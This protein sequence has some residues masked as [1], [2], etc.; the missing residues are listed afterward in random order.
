MDIY[1]LNS[2]L[3]QL[4]IIDSFKSL[5]W[6]KRYYTCGDF[7]LCMAADLEK[8]KFLQPDN[9]L[10]RE[11]DE[12]VMVIEKIEAHYD[13]DEG[14]L[15]IVSGRSLESLLTRRVCSHIVSIN[16]PDVVSGIKTLI[17]AETPS[18]NSSEYRSIPHLVIDDS[19][20]VE[21]RLKTQFTGDV[22]LDAV[23]AICKTYKIGLKMTISGSDIVLAFYAGQRSAA[24]FSN[25]FDNLINSRYLFDRETVANFAYVGG[26]GEGISRTVVE[27]AAYTPPAT[28]LNRREIW[29]D[30]RDIDDTDESL[31]LQLL[32][33]RG[34]QKLA[35]N[36]VVQ[37]F[38]AEIEPF[39]SFKYKVDF[40][41][42]DIVTVQNEYGITANPR[43]VEIVESWD[44]TGYTMIPTFDSLDI[45]DHVVLKDSNGKI[46]KDSSGKIVCEGVKLWQNSMSN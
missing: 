30:A 35:E 13:S 43:I 46:L 45:P 24:V 18:H 27:M 26:Q 42:G 12:T 16:T 36:Q 33:Q 31:Y 4:A 3:E 37:T 11:D 9:F 32:I 40:N 5:I 28:G 38:E 44:E 41:L 34:R 2:D 22:L 21:E 15:F 20:T 17:E 7:E 39:S 6:T 14:A 8:L 1:V 19:F 10:I 25:E 23:T 29:V